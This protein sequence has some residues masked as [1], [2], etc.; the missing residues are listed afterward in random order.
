MFFRKKDAK[1]PLKYPTATSFWDPRKVEA[2][3]SSTSVSINLT[4]FIDER[5]SGRHANYSA[6]A[7]SQ[8]AHGFTDWP[9]S[10]VMITFHDGPIEDHP[11][12]KAP[13]I[14]KWMYEVFGNK[15]D[16]YLGRLLFT[17]LDQDKSIRTALKSA[18]AATLASGLVLTNLIILK[19]KGVGDFS[20]KDREYGCSYDSRYPFCG[21]LVTERHQSRHLKKWAVPYFDDDFSPERAPF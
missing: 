17:F 7:P 8:V 21:M 10:L 6:L 19:E 4:S 12:P 13:T 11:A 2:I 3:T 14:G 15:H 5:C 1:Q 18:H 9:H 20:T 16:G